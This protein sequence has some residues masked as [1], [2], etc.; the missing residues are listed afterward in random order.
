MQRIIALNCPDWSIIA[1]GADPRLPVIVRKQEQVVACSQ[2]ARAAGIAVGIRRR[3]AQARCPEVQIVAAD[4]ARD[5]AAF[6]PILAAIA[7]LVPEI[8]LERPGSLTLPSR[9]PARRF[10]GEAAFAHHLRQVVDAA[11][12]DSYQAQTGLCVERDALPASRVGIADGWYAAILA[13]RVADPCRIIAPG[14]SRSFLATFPVRA[15]TGAMDDAATLIATCE[16]LGIATLGAFAALTATQVN[17]RFGA[18]GLFAWHVA[19]GEEHPAHQHVGPIEALESI[20]VLDPPEQQTEAVG[21]AVRQDAEAFLATL[22]RRSLLG[23]LIEIAIETAHG[24]QLVRQWRSTAGF[25]AA[26]LV[27]R[28]RWQLDGWLQ[29]GTHATMPTAGVSLV[30]FCAVEV[31][32]GGKQLAVTDAERQNDQQVAQTMARLQGLLGPEEILVGVPAA[33]RDPA[34]WVVAAPWRTTGTASS[35]HGQKDAPWPGRLLPPA[36][37]I[38]PEVPVV[39]DVVDRQGATVQVS[40]R[41]ELSSPPAQLRSGRESWQ[42]IERWTGPWP[43]DERWWDDGGRRRARMQVVTETGAGRLLMVE[44]GQWHIEAFYD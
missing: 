2:A 40:G 5:A 34:Q 41:G 19:Q 16:R 27:D 30:R 22:R 10:G 3:E 25:T 43:A 13:A 24:E 20:V 32:E 8:A 7:E 37:T 35:A 17:D 42:S 14:Q 31:L 1:A 18:R 36:P 21:F 38:I 33:G 4:P 9:G 29:A 26:A 11:V 39:A 28:L 15:L 12:L 23:V 44:N 6:A